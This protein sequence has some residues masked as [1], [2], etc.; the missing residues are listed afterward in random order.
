MAGR[1]PLYF[2][3]AGRRFFS[4]LAFSGFALAFVTMLATYAFWYQF[5][6]TFL[7]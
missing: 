2:S 7:G 1:S 4:G 5:T 6:E 3:C